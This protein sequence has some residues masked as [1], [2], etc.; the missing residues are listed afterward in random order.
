MRRRRFLK[1]AGVGASAL[2]AGCTAEN[3]A[4]TPTDPGGTGTPTGTTTGTPSG[5]PTLLV[6]TYESF[7]DAPSSSPGAWVKET[8]ESEFDAELEWFVPNNQ[9]NYFIQRKNQGVTIDT[10]LYLGLTPENLVQADTELSEGSLFEPVDTDGFENAGHLKENFRFDPQDRA[11]PFGASFIS[12]VYNQD[13]L[14]EQGIPAPQ[15]FEDLTKP[16]YEGAVV[17]PN[18]QNSETGLEFLFWTIIEYGEDGY[19]DYWRRLQ[20]NGVR[21]LKSWGAAYSAYSNGE[22]PIVVSYSTD[23]VFADQ[24]DEPLSQHQ[25]GFLNDQGYQY[26]EGM[27]RIAGTDKPDLAADFMDFMLR[28]DVQSEVAVRNVA[29][30]VVDNA[31]LPSDFEELTKEPEDPVGFGYDDLMGNVSDWLD[32]WSRQIA[33]Q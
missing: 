33:S 16:E 9:L 32:A 13:A 23:Q 28:A 5:T 17:C 27:A 7:V 15:T 3:V 10:D 6:T 31:E 29:N 24:Y 11:I 19:L 18:P 12:L 8:F 20:E 1:G 4:D 30:P 21:I 14:D 25:V 26:V 2:L 22:A